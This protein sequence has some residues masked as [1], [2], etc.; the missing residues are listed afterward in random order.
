MLRIWTAAF[1]AA[2]LLAGASTADAPRPFPEFS[3][4]RALPPKPGTTR[5]ITVQIDPSLAPEA[6]PVAAEPPAAAPE[7]A[8][9]WFWQSVATDL[10]TAPA[11]RL[12]AALTALETVAGGRQDIAAPR[13]QDLRRIAETYGIDILTASLDTVVSPALALAVIAVES[14]GRVDAVSSAGAK[15]LM[16]LMPATAERFGV[17]DATARENI[18]GGV[19]YL[20][21]LI[22]HFAGDEVLALAGYNAGEGAVREHGGVP[23]FAETRD[24][25]PKVLAAWRVARALCMSP[26]ELV[27]DGCVFQ[28]QMARN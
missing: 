21:W 22:R 7:G 5:F 28:G 4:K 18:R 12:E 11:M 8:Y 26:P 6:A 27:S 3:A 9:G 24:Y 19:E 10:G 14:S 23:P 2:L 1:A 20:D 15:G 17:T 16:Q 25:V 13:L